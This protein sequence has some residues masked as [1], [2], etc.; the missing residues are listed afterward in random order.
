MMIAVQFPSKLVCLLAVLTLA[1]GCAES[2]S[3]EVAGVRSQLMLESQP[4]GVVPIEK[5]RQLLAEDDAPQEI[6]LTV[7]VGNKDFP[8]WYFDEGA[9]MVVSEA[10]PGSDYNVGPDHD[11][12]TCPFCRWKWKNED[13]LAMVEFVD[14]DGNVRPERCDELLGVE[15]GDVLTIRGMASLDEVGHLNLRPTGIFHHL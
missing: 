3:P 14:D 5:A 2:V 15:A 13:S 12:S 4:E 10:F 7:R 9:I 11:S 6:V 8:Q 1:S